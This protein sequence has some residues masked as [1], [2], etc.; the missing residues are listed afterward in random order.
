MI[1]A[2]AGYVVSALQHLRRTGAPALDVRPEVQAA[3]DAEMQRRLQHSILTACQSWYR[4][5][6]GRIVNNWP[7]YMKEY[8]DATRALDPSEYRLV[9][10]RRDREPAGAAQ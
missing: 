9:R 10:G 6:D 4:E 7:G 1:E 3:S 2:Q 5:A 8:V